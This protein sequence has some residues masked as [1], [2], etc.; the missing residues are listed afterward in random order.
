MF[1]V[2]RRKDREHSETS[3]PLLEDAEN[4][5][6]DAQTIFAID[7]EDVEHEAE[8]ADPTDETFGKNTPN[9]H[10][11]FQDHV[12]FIAP[13]LRSNV[14]SRETGEAIFMTQIRAC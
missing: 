1:S 10:V 4:D 11:R 13:S 5:L 3:Q 6:H 7:D 9:G 2:G 8:L 14:A 12:D